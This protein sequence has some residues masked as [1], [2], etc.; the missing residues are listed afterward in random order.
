MLSTAFGY[1]RPARLAARFAFAFCR[2]VSGLASPF[3]R[4]RFQIGFRVR[5]FSLRDTSGVLPDLS[6]QPCVRALA[7][8]TKLLSV[9]RDAVLRR[10]WSMARLV[11]SQPPTCPQLLL[12]LGRAS[13]PCSTTWGVERRRK[14]TRS[15]RLILCRRL[16][17]STADWCELDGLAFDVAPSDLLRKHAG[18]R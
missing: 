10:R 2:R 6:T 9:R 5:L 18:V 15:W 4:G 13:A 7:P 17:N 14:K 11:Y 3:G 16:P 12:S 8:R 1:G